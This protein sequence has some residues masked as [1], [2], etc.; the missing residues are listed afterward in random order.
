[1]AA[2]EDA[3]EHHGGDDRHRIG[4]EEVGRHAGAIADIVAHIIRDRRRIARIIL[5]NPGLDLADEI[6]ADI[7]ALGEDA[8]AEPREDRDER[9]TESERD[10]RIDHRTIIP[11]IARR[12]P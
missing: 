7:G 1:M 2:E 5:G 9:S 3:A 10:E 11:S 12:Y 8:A 4:L 6:G